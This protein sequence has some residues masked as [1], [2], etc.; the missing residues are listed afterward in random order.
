[1]ANTPPNPPNID[2]WDNLPLDP[3]ADDWD[4]EPTP[5]AVS[6]KEAVKREEEPLKAKSA[7]DTFDAITEELP[8]WSDEPENSKPA[9]DQDELDETDEFLDLSPIEALEEASGPK[10]S[11]APEDSWDSP[12]TP[13]PLKEAKNP[14]PED[15][16]DAQKA[17]V[18][19]KD[20]KSLGAEDSWDAQATQ[21]PPKDAKSLGAEDSWDAQASPEPPKDVK[22]LGAEDSWDAQTALEKKEETAADDKDGSFDFEEVL[23]AQS[24]SSLDLDEKTPGARMGDEDFPDKP[25]PDDDSDAKVSDPSDPSDPNREG[26]LQSLGDLD[27]VE[28]ENVPK[29]VELD[30]DGIFNEAKKE[31]ESLSPEA[32]HFPEEAPTDKPL[33]ATEKPIPITPETTGPS[34]PVKF[35]RYK[36][37]IFIGLIVVAVAGLGFG[38]YR[39]FLRSPVEEPPP[40]EE[41]VI[42][43]DLAV[44][45][46]K[47]PGVFT[48]D[49]FYVSLGEEPDKTV[50]E[51]EIILHYQDEPVVEVIKTEMVMIRDLIYRLTKSMSPSMLTE[52]DERRQL[53]ANLL[54]TL[55]SLPS[56]MSDP[57]DPALTYVQI[58]LLKKR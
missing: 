51:M 19:P 26:F 5:P 39:I 13:E 50:V 38:V 58:S 1:M 37:F 6:S 41:F 42:E 20:Q 23:K 54:T 29:K 40:K 24:S 2:D 16:W 21:E 31:A 30:L 46:V 9:E 28:E 10:P 36:L 57:A 53:Q 35:A 56:F 55:N 25:N 17:P 22:G 12:A 3:G 49:R 34:H 44:V 11:L 4:E 8:S 7:E 18:P 47:T 27:E 32:T 43:D 15:S 45:R 33:E 14:Q 52:M 48:L